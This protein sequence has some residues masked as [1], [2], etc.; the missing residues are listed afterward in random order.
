MSNY[1]GGLLEIA[2]KINDSVKNSTL[3][4]FHQARREMQGKLR[5]ADSELFSFKG[6]HD[7]YLMHHGGRSE[8]QFNIGYDVDGTGNEIIRFGVAFSFDKSKWVNNP[9]EALLPKVHLF[10]DYMNRESH[11]FND[12]RMWH[13]GSRGRSPDRLPQSISDDVL[14]EAQ[15]IF[16]GATQSETDVDYNHVSSVLQRLYQI[17]LYIETAGQRDIPEALKY[18]A[19]FRFVP[20]NSNKRSMT[21][22]NRLARHVQ[23]SLR[24]NDLQHQLFSELVSEYGLDAVGTEIRA[25]AGGYIDIVVSMADEDNWTKRLRYYEIKTASTAKECIRQAMGQ[26]LEYS[27]FPNNIDANELI[28]VGEPDLTLDD[29][30]YLNRLNKSL[31]LPIRYRKI[32]FPRESEQ[33]GSGRI[34]TPN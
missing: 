4:H 30:I 32:V 28:V 33:T 1:E 17:Y 2:H 19:T 20:G 16:I 11:R 18:A 7:T 8:L 10:N 26:L 15:F 12:L 27:Y 25:P 13:H 5:A 29:K 3:G 6:Y 21:H 31:S 14:S 9:L 23:I 24:H 34:D 22:F